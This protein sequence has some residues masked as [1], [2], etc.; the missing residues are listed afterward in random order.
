MRYFIVLLALFTG[1]AQAEIYRSTTADGEVIFSDQPGPGAEKVQLPELP[2]YKAPPV[3]ARAGGAEQKPPAKSLYQ[4]MVF[5]TPGDDA[6]VR[7]NL[8][9]LTASV[10][11]QP[12]LKT[13]LGHRVQFYLDNAPHGE[14]IAGTAVSFTGLDRGSHL[15]SASVVDAQG[16]TII[17]S[18]TV[19][20]HLHRESI[21]LPSRKA[22]ARKP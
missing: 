5:T 2:T 4:E 17:S 12:V 9:A 16:N 18:D 8:G 22:P 21:N 13:R 3:G 19:I 6:T 11:L 10:S 7:N 15:L 14:P 1:V 20:F